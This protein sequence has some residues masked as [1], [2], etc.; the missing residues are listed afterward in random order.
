[1]VSIYIFMGVSVAILGSWSVLSIRKTKGDPIVFLIDEL[2]KLKKKKSG[3]T[4][5]FLEWDNP[6]HNGTVLKTK[7]HKISQDAT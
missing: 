6:G 2:Q 1:M 3:I 5:Q 7:R 4:P